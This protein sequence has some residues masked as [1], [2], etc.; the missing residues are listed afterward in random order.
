MYRWFLG[1]VS[2]YLVRK[3]FMLTPRR[4][5]EDTGREIKLENI[6]YRQRKIEQKRWALRLQLESLA[7]KAGVRWEA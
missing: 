7:K 5:T 6:R 4:S 3:H 1:K 2:N